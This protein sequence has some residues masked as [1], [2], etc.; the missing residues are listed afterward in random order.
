MRCE[1]CRRLILN[2]HYTKFTDSKVHY[3]HKTCFDIFS[4]GGIKKI[5]RK[6]PEDIGTSAKTKL[7]KTFEHTNSYSYLKSEFNN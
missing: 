4:N 2:H 7:R 3:F 5:K 1:C 6:N